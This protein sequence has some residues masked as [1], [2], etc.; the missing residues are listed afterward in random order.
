MSHSTTHLLVSDLFP[1]DAIGN[2]VLGIKE[3]L[4]MQN[5]QTALYAE[6]YASGMPVAGTYL[7]F[8]QR[9]Q[10]DDVLLYQLSNGDP[11]FSDLMQVACKKVVYYHNI[12]PGLFFRPTHAETA[13]VLDAGRAMLPLLSA[14]DAVYANSWWSLHEVIPYL[15]PHAMRG[16]MPP[17]TKKSLAFS[18]ERQTFTQPDAPYLLTVGRIIPHKNTLWAIRLFAALHT[19]LPN[20]TFV[21]MGDGFGGYELNVRKFAATMLPENRIRFTGSVSDAEAATLFQGATGL[22]CASLHEGF[23]VPLVE[24]MAYGVP[25]FALEQPA[26]SETLNGAGIL[27]TADVAV[28]AERLAHIVQNTELMRALQHKGLHRVKEL[29]DNVLDSSFWN[30]IVHG[31]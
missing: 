31:E 28:E 12:T 6:R 11:A 3:T 22:V 10:P 25:V 30:V 7:D 4:R 24:A 21:V 23:G 29:R 2:F 26:V 17:L 20:F 16:V 8:F 15:Q 13:D 27:L 14:A 1:R 5:V 18:E 9:V 19:L